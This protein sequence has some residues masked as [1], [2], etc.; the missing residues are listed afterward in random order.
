MLNARQ[1]T[2]RDSSHVE[3]NAE[4]GVCLQ[5]V[6]ADAFLALK[7]LAAE[8]GIDLEAVSSFRDFDSQAA[9]WNDKFRGKRP[10]Y[11]ADGV[12]LEHP[13]LSRE[14]LVSSIL[15]WSALPG[16]SRHHWGSDF[17]VIDRAAVPEGY[18]VRLV[19]EEFGSDGVFWR[20]GEWLDSHLQETDFFRPYLKYNGGVEREAWH[21]SFAPIAVPALESLKL[22]TLEQSLVDSDVLGMDIVTPR[23][24]DIYEKYVLNV[25]GPA[26]RA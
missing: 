24:P 12:E 18:E 6:V 23:L 17:D 13:V 22:E 15:R 26:D 1:L 25:S 5:P 16:A 9:I 19:N 7:A 14:D 11:D 10:I 4:S 8:A 20:L 21:L 3:T 2:G